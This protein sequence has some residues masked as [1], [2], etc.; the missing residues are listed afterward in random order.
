MCIFPTRLSNDGHEV[1]GIRL[2]LEN[3]KVVKA[4]AEKNE[5]FLIR[6]LDTD[7]GSRYLGEFAYRNE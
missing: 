3:G 2:W 5:A 4:T 6:T 1:T 7:E